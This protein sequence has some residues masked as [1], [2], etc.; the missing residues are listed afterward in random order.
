MKLEILLKIGEKYAFDSSVGSLRK[1]PFH[2][3]T[4]EIDYSIDVDE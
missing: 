3:K 1:T 2:F 4:S